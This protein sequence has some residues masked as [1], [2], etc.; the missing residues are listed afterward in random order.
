KVAKEYLAIV[1]GSPNET[2]LESL[3]K[4]VDLDDG[5][6]AP[7][8][9]EVVSFEATPGAPRTE[10]RVMIRE[11]RHRQV[12]RMLNAV[13]HKVLSLRRTGFGPLKLGRLKVGDWRLLGE[14]E[15]EALRRA[16]RIEP[17]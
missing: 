8:E 13:G 14:P 15:V 16:V 7:A 1:V 6:T 17:S 5:R 4:G 9:V 2:D 11:G 12:R 10:L 3:R